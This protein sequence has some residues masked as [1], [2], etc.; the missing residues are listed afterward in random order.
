M[1]LC[2]YLPLRNF[3]ELTGTL[4]WLS[5]FEA[6]GLTPPVTLVLLAFQGW[7]FRDNFLFG[8]GLKDFLRCCYHAAGGVT[9]WAV[10]ATVLW[11]LTLRRFQALTIRIQESGGR[12]QEPGVRR[13]G[14][15]VRSQES[16][17][18]S[19]EPEVRI[20]DQRSAGQTHRPATKPLLPDS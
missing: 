10:A 4:K 3:A 6:F 13:Q 1:T 11:F 16:G 19:Q 18:R 9:C 8:L 17:V 14:S 12:N 20:R 2:V 15:G 5:E 7:E